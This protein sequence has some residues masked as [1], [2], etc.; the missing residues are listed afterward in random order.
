MESG[1]T[2]NI[3]GATGFPQAPSLTIQSS[4]LIA[5]GNNTINGG[6]LIGTN[7]DLTVYTQGNLTINSAVLDTT[8]ITKAGAGTLTLTSNYYGGAITVAQGTLKVANS[9]NSMFINQDLV[10][11][12]GWAIGGALPWVRCSNRR[13]FAW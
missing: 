3:N 1:A 4:G 10:V 6:L 9:L 8:G 12:P 5:M 7:G 13:A 11:N 2:L